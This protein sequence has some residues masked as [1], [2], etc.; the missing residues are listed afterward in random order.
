M[1]AP[2]AFLPQ[3]L[4]G[5]A[6]S[7]L[8]ALGTLG[9]SPAL[10]DPA[11]PDPASADVP[12]A[13][14]RALTVPYEQYSL[15]NGLDV[16]LHRDA[17][18]PFVA[19]N[20]WYH[21][22]PANE[23][24]HRSGFAHL[25]EHLMFEGSLH[26]GDDFDELLE[27]V[28]GT[29]VNGTTSWDRT[30]YYETVP[31]EHLALALWIESDRMAYL[32][33][34]LTA[35]SLEKQK[36]I[37]LNERRQTYENAPYGPSSLAL[38]DALFPPGHPYHGSVIGSVSDI[39][40]A[41]MADVRAFYETY[42]APSNATLAIAG[43]FEPEAAKALVEKYFGTL[44]RRPSPPRSRQVTPPLA[45]AS[46]QVV[47]EPVELGQVTMGWLVPPAY[48]PDDAALEVLSYVLAGGRATLLYRELVVKQKVASNVAAY[49]DGA[50]LTGMF[51]VEVTG[52]S[53]VEGAALEQATEQV[54]AQVAASGPE[55]AAVARAKRR[56]LVGLYAALQQ[57]N[58][59]GGESGRAGLLQR[60]NHY[61]GDPG[62]LP[63]Y[64]AALEAVTI[65]DVQ[66]A[67]AT[68]LAPSRRATVVT[69]PAPQQGAPR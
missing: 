55:P 14:S 19:I 34:H 27:A 50:G 26:V 63:R 23:P 4:G 21:V 62:Y 36:G 6:T 57:L 9:S 17:T 54:L 1:K 16:I 8:V 24:H 58:G 68:H 22:G 5:L 47:E 15:S 31:R 38:F 60:F 37:V 10:A 45:K 67:A 51:V 49:L 66:R 69:R 56:I 40:A 48:A 30:N 41:S 33:D 13:Q 65:Q 18:L 11:R 7:A 42:Y 3:V 2:S 32:L 25:F 39:S 64:V 28:G 61:V 53:G 59:G 29:N 43:D 46:R 52:A 35:A 12:G 44:A 20:V